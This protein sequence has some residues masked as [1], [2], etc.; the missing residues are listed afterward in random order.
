MLR[1][2]ALEHGTSRT[3]PFL[4]WTARVERKNANGLFLPARLAASAMET[5]PN[6]RRS[7]QPLRDAAPGGAVPIFSHRQPGQPGPKLHYYDRISDYTREYVH[8][9]YYQ[10]GSSGVPTN[11]R[12]IDIGGWSRLSI[13]QLRILFRRL[14]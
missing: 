6:A 14:K 3:K 11:W 8:H 9:P 12:R 5:R 7:S 10:P 2:P 4:A 13:Y 1:A